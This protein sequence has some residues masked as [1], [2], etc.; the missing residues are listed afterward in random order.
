MDTKDL[1]NNIIQKVLDTD[2]NQLLDYLYKLL[3][4]N[5][6][7]DLYQLSEFE[8]SIISKSLEDY[9]EGNVVSHE[10]VISRNRKWLKE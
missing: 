2:D 5:D 8:K 1:Q 9:K 4:N 3:N 10:D 7:K 6:N